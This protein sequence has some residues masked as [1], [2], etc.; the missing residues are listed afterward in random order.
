ME[1]QKLKAADYDPFIPNELTDAVSVEVRRRHALEDVRKEHF[2][3][4]N[5]LM[6]GYDAKIIAVHA[7]FDAM[8]KIVRRAA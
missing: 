1:H 4:L 7:H 8:E 3:A 5:N 2:K 6:D